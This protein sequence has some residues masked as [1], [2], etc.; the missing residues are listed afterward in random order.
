MGLSTSN[1]ESELILN[2]ISRVPRLGLGISTAGFGLDLTA[3]SLIGIAFGL[4]LSG[5]FV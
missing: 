2:G 3:T 5:F 1:D 4:T